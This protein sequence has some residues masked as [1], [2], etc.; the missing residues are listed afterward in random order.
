LYIAEI[1][2]PGGFGQWP[3]AGLA[4]TNWCH[5]EKRKRRNNL[6]S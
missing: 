5:C 4:M 1:A 3:A 6:G 2:T